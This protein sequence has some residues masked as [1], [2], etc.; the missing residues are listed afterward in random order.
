MISTTILSN[1][2][3]LTT[4]RFIRFAC[5]DMLC[6]SHDASERKAL[7]KRKTYPEVFFYN[8]NEN[9]S[10]MDHIF[11]FFIRYARAQLAPHSTDCPI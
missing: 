1:L 10:Q 3:T 5:F 11:L 9:H 8:D 2:K 7:E 6:D 4:V